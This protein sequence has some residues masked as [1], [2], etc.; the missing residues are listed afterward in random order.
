MTVFAIYTF[1]EPAL[2]ARTISRLEGAQIVVH[3]DKKVAIEPFQAAIASEDR[4]RV[5]FLTDRVQVNWAGYSQL[6]AIRRM[7]QAALQ[8][9]APEEYVFLLSGQDYPIKPMSELERFLAESNGKQYLRYIQIEDTPEQRLYVNNVKWRHFRDLDMLSRHIHITPLR[10]FRTLT[11]RTLE[12][13]ARFFR[14]L[15]LWGKMPVG[16]GSSYFAVTASFLQ[17]LEDRVTPE[18]DQYFR[19]IFCPEESFYHTLSLNSPRGHET[20]GPRPGGAQEFV[21]ANTFRYSNL[22]EITPV[23]EH[24]M[25]DSDFDLLAGSWKFFARKFSSK[26]SA[27]LL[28]R[29]DRELLHIPPM[30]KVDAAPTAG[31]TVD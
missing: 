29:I 25:D 9:A 8:L 16:F 3:V 24:V 4:S 12:Y 18:I 23:L 19:H 30:R 5:T 26:T 17:S 21:G 10:K 22:H 20:G 31:A 7:M 14:P 2:L 6:T 11:E 13:L 27:A 15:P 28:D 1:K